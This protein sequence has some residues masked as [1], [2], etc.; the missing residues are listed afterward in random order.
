MRPPAHGG[1]AAALLSVV[2]AALSY[3]YMAAAWG[4]YVFVANI[5]ALHACTLLLL[6]RR[7]AHVWRCYSLFYALGARVGT[8]TLTLP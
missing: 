6:G 5:M 8:L 7:P 1:A 4:G 2:A 3:S